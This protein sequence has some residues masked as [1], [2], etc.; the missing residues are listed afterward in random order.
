MD[1][2]PEGHEGVNFIALVERPA[3]QRGFLAFGEAQAQPM[4]FAV[5]SE[6]RRIVSGPLMLADTPIYR[7]PPQVPQACY[8]TV[9]PAVIERVARNF[10]AFGFHK[11]VNLEHDPERQIEGVVMFESFINDSTRGIAPPKG[12]EDAPEGSW[13]SSFFVDN[14]E[15]W[16][17]VKD[18]T[19]TG[20]SVEGLFHLLRTPDPY[21]AAMAEIGKILENLE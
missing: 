17:Q 20:F 4:A 18:G 11:N 14:D 13:F 19:F 1:F 2:N 5:T 16:Q 10:H 15:V 9:T 12:F 7:A 3:I 6:D 21:E 8:V